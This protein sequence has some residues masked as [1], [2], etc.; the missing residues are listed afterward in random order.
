MATIN[1]DDR[2]LLETP[3]D[4]TTQEQAEHLAALIL[5][6]THDL[7]R[8]VQCEKNSFRDGTYR[9]IVFPRLARARAALQAASA[10]TAIVF[11]DLNTTRNCARMVVSTATRFHQLGKSD[12]QITVA[13]HVAEQ[14][15]QA[16]LGASYE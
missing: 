2:D 4:I 14:H 10:P 16:I 13:D 6:W 15:R 5:A 12:M 9:V 8:D 3:T 11:V 7:V 1:P